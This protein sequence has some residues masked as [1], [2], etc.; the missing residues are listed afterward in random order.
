MGEDADRPKYTNADLNNQLNA[1]GSVSGIEVSQT[2]SEAMLT[3]TSLSS[4]ISNDIASAGH[5]A[6]ACS[7]LLQQ[8]E[9]QGKDD[10][11]RKVLAKIEPAAQSPR[12]PSESSRACVPFH[13]LPS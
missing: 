2:E 6:F 3:A 13:S 5:P 9:L 11:S 10:R 7:S 12:L 4:Q 8:G 1:T